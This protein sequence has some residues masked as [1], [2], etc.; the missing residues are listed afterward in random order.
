MPE[1]LLKAIQDDD[2]KKSSSKLWKKEPSEILEGFRND[3]MASYAGK[4]LHDLS[5][6]LWETAGWD[7]IVAHNKR[8]PKPL[9]ENELRGVFESIKKYPT[10]ESKINSTIEQC[11]LLLSKIPKDTPKESVL[12]ILMPLLETLAF[13]TSLEEAEIYIRNKIKNELNITTNDINS[14][15]KHSKK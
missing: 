1:W 6:G 5:P 9:S 12:K 10:D 3:V 11:D 4:V 2:K 13:G 7:S 14:I 15:I 8:I